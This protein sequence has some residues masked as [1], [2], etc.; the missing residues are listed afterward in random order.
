MEYIF[1]TS[2]KR[3]D[4]ST[5]EL[6]KESSCLTS[7]LCRQVEKMFVEKSHSKISPLRYLTK[8]FATIRWKRKR[9]KQ[10]IDTKKCF[11]KHEHVLG[12]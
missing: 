5:E 7:V 9:S 2:E 1:N 12:R 3:T 10:N 8:Q 4:L 6:N 11:N